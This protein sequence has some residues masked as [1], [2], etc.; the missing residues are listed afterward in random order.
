MMP[1]W[2]PVRPA[3]ASGR[4]AP[5]SWCKRPATPLATACTPNSMMRVIPSDTITMVIGDAPRRWNGEYT[6]GIHQRGQQ[7]AG[8][9]RD[10]QA[11]PH[12]D[13]CCC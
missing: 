12:R 4:W 7:R 9:H 8:D 10:Q 6:P 11:Q 5:A 13:G 1:S 3:A 2:R